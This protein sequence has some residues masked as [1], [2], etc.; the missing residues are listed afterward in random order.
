[1]NGEGY[2]DPTADAAVR[3]VSRDAVTNGKL[4][5]FCRARPTDC[6]CG[7]CKYW[8]HCNEFHR[9]N[10]HL[11]TSINPDEQSRMFLEEEIIIRKRRKRA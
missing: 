2:R 5:R 7:G 11:P 9:T 3:N 4:I 1:M 10:G 8:D 6:T